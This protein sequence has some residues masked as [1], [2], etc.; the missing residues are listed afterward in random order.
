MRKDLEDGNWVFD[1]REVGADGKPVGKLDLFTPF[2]F[3][4]LEVGVYNNVCHGIARI[5]ILIQSNVVV[6]IW[7]SCHDLSWGKSELKL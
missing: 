6:Q 4:L 7:E 3:V 5:L 1:I 2:S